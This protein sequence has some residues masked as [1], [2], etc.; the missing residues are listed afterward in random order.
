MDVGL[1]VG[2]GDLGVVWLDGVVVE[3]VVVLLEIFDVVKL[4]IAVVVVGF[5][6]V[7]GN[8]GIVVGCVAGPLFS[9]PSTFLLSIRLG[10]SGSVCSFRILIRLT[11]F[12]SEWFLVITLTGGEYSNLQ[13]FDFAGLSYTL[14]GL[15]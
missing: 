4:G 7:V 3:E 15:N 9:I 14:H 13:L 8:V 5:F 6:E 11:I 10:R 1:V 2:V 12:N